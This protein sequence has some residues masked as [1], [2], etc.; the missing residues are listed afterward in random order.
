MTGTEIGSISCTTGGHPRPRMPPAN[1]SSRPSTAA[2]PP[3][4]SDSQGA[5][6]NSKRQSRRM[7]RIDNDI[8]MLGGVA[9]KSELLRLGFTADHVLAAV[10]RGDIRR[11]RKGWYTVPDLRE[12]VF[13]AVR[14]GGRLACVS[15]ARHHGLWVPSSDLEL[16]VDVPGSGSRLRTT[17][18]H[19]QRLASHPDDSIVI[20]WRKDS[21]R[22][23]DRLAVAI[24]DCIDQVYR[25]QGEAA[26]FVVLESALNQHR[27]TAAEQHSLLAM[28]PQPSR[29][30][31]QR[32]SALSQ[33]G[34][35]SL[36]RLRLLS[37]RIGFRQQ[38]QVRGVGRVDFL[39]GDRL[40]IEV[41]SKEHHSDPYADRR[42]DA[43]LSALGYR[44]L[45]FMYSQV[46]YE[47]R[48]VEA[49]ILA[50][51]SR[52]DHLAA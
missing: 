30:V 28:L 12:S 52:G 43:A 41:D 29:P 35:E 13:R 17:T 6:A 11:A 21:E 45:R 14:V 49:A 20:H 4:V 10:K 5:G 22:P 3:E 42:R 8:R 7:R 9:K 36:V 34:T 38:V 19:R 46:V 51:I 16:H 32:A 24:P 15:A 50:A 23:G 2:G 26:G 44:V 47:W 48:S 18:N 33:S 39:V 40:I 25:C 37:L 1:P 27:L 31:A